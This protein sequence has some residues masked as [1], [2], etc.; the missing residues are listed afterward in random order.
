M[1]TKMIDGVSA[2]HA[3]VPAC[4]R[5]LLLWLFGLLL[6]GVT[7]A[8]AA[9]RSPA[10]IAAKPKL[11]LLALGEG[12]AAV[13][14]DLLFAEFAKEMR[15]ALVE[16]QAI[17]AVRRELDLA[18]LSQP[19]ARLA[20]GQRLAADFLLLCDELAPDKKLRLRLVDAPTGI[21]L[22]LETLPAACW[23]VAESFSNSG[24]IP[25]A[26]VRRNP[27]P[28]QGGMQ[29]YASL[30]Q[31]FVLRGER[32]RRYNRGVTTG[33]GAGELTT[34]DTDSTDRDRIG[35]SVPSVKSVVLRVTGAGTEDEREELPSNSIDNRG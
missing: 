34:D 32:A 1:M 3:Q 20:L 13:L 25:P 11:A 9:V 12:N 5:V 4:L 15:L 21:V 7:A 28:R 33:P 18:A 29:N 35:T 24:T 2:L 23:A 22:F 6:C 27:R 16:R 30:G 8:P 31:A 10:E 19:A 14:G 26:P 17:D